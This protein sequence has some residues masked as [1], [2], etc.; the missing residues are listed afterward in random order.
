MALIGKLGI[1]AA[2]AALQ[3]WFAV[4]VA[5]DM[6]GG[7]RVNQLN[8]ADPVTSIARDQHWI[9]NFLIVICVIIFVGVFSVMFYS[10]WKHRKSVGHQPADF[11]ESTWVEI[12]WTIVPFLIVIGMALPATRMVVEQKDT[13][14][15]DITVKAVG[16]Q[17]KWGYEYLKGEGEGISFLSTLTTPR[18]QID[19]R[20]EKSLTYLTEVD[21]PLVVPVNKK[22]R[23]VTTAND[24]IHAW[25]VPA[26]GVKQDAIP[27]F[28][29]D[30]W[31][32]AE[33]VGTYRGYC[34]ELCGK[35][36]AFM[37]IVVEVKSEADYATWV[38]ERK[39][40]MLA[41]ADDPNK[42]WALDTLV[43]RGESVYA[44]NCAAC[45]QANGQGVPGAFP[46][47]AGSAVV[48]GPQEA[49]IEVLLKGRTGTAMAAFKQLS[50]V[51]LAAVSTYVR[52]AFG[53]APQDNI[54]QPREFGAAR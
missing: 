6:P 46:A 23:V 12:A 32:R 48:T 19:G 30:T 28:V 40:E 10:V 24:V 39:A 11:H 22:I 2:A 54:I 51:E 8:L 18:E 47:L 36:H 15:A 42:E 9:H 21:N 26:F 50:D 49:Q 5:A 37:P 41:K 3:S 44:A 16:Y 33:K 17:W 13:A 53:N 20:A 34:T 27:G 38:A 31:F 25:M 29:R 45:H 7:P 4:A 35:D 52:N 14:N 1:A 43:A